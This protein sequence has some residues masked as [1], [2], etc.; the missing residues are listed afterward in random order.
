[1]NASQTP[2]RPAPAADTAPP[3]ILADLLNEFGPHL[4]ASRIRG[5]WKARRRAAATKGDRTP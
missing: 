3:S 2:A 1:V 5:V 4:V